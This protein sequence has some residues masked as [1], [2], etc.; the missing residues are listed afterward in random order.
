MTAGE[1]YARRTALVLL[2]G[3]V[4]AACTAAVSPD[5][6]NGGPGAAVATPPVVPESEAAPTTTLPPP[7]EALVPPGYGTLKQDQVTVALRIGP[8]LVK[9]TPLSESV[10]RLLAP[11]TYTRLHGLAESRRAEA[12]SRTVRAPELFLV[13]FFSYQPDVSFQPEDVQL[14]HQGQLLRP[15]GIFPITGGWGSQR[16]Q[17]QDNQ[18]AIYAFE[19]TIDYDQPHTVRYGP[20]EADAWRNV[21]PLLRAERNKVL[22]RVGGSGR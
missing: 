6:G 4:G 7:Q 16:L 18:S 11:D 2:L 21:I 17:Q 1:E 8:L 12:A 19:S 5:I 10:I 9:V 22:S 14:L 3:C 20:E 15:A 13:S